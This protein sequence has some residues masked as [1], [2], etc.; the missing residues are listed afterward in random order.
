M[1]WLF[2]LAERSRTVVQ[3]PSPIYN[4]TDNVATNMVN[5]S[6]SIGSI[7][8]SLDRSTTGFPCKYIETDDM[9]DK[10]ASVTELPSVSAGLD[11]KQSSR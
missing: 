11:P 5:E 2:R 4:T 8:G 10:A 1:Y 7:D 6:H 9:G 3:I